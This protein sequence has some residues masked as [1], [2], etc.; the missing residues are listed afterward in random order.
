MAFL[1][2]QEVQPT[3]TVELPVVSA[4]VADDVPAPV[5]VLPPTQLDWTPPFSLDT[6][7]FAP[8]SAQAWKMGAESITG[9]IM[10]LAGVVREERAARLLAEAKTAEVAFL[11][12]QALDASNGGSKPAASAANG[13]RQDLRWKSWE[14]KA[15]VSEELSASRFDALSRDVAS[16]ALSQ[17]LDAL[18]DDLATQ[19]AQI[20][21]QVGKETRAALQEGV[22][23]EANN[24]RDQFERINAALNARLDLVD[25]RLE[26]V[27]LANP[28]EIKKAKE[29]STARPPSSAEPSKQAPLKEDTIQASPKASSAAQQEV[30]DAPSRQSGPASPETAPE[31]QQGETQKQK[32]EVMQ[33]LDGAGSHQELVAILKALESRVK[34]LE[35]KKP[36]ATAA[37]SKP[38]KSA[39]DDVGPAQQVSASAA[40]PAA[41]A[42]PIIEQPDESLSPRTEAHFA[43]LRQELLETLDIRLSEL[44][45]TLAQG[46]PASAVP[47]TVGQEPK[48]IAASDKAPAAEPVAAPIGLPAVTAAMPT[49]LPA[50]AAQP[51][52][53]QSSLSLIHI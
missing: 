45:T 6:A 32:P 48:A 18:R 25:Q 24:L 29:L 9:A 39:K 37:S 20:R 13:D 11:A 40:Q 3:P 43:H 5:T 38:A 2:P 15:K 33:A 14:A 16:R 30:K 17:D 47:T 21:Q 42:T 1:P 27:S 44:Q 26:E 51:V 41:A 8:G 19:A 49:D 10:W 12:Q 31:Q 52:V 46:L 7:P 22:A 53:S 34:D 35:S 50:A 36:G 4:I 28:E 23:R